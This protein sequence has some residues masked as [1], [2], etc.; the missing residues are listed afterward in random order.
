VLVARVHTTD[1]D[2]FPL[3]GYIVGLKDSLYRFSDLG[4]NTITG[5]ESNGVFAAIFG[6]LEDIGLN[7]GERSR[8]DRRA[9]ERS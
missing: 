9:N 5:D 8:R 4:T 7:T 1:V 3:N 2:L 6:G